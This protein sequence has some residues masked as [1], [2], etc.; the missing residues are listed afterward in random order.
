MLVIKGGGGWR[1]EGGRKRP[2]S[3]GRAGLRGLGL[4]LTV[5][6][7]LHAPS[8]FVVSVSVSSLLSQCLVRA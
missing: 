8:M 6:R 5:D 4:L 3:G 7:S 1:E 2:C